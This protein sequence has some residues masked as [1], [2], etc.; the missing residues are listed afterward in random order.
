M[1]TIGAAIANLLT[2]IFYFLLYYL[3][4][5]RIYYIKYEVSKLITIALIG[6][7]LVLLSMATIE[8]SIMV[9]MSLK[10]VLFCSYPFLLYMMRFYDDI[11]LV[12]LQ[13]AWNKWKHPLQWKELIRSL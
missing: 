4:A 5:R 6:T 12:R 11:E 1:Q 13:Q 2:Q 9:R 3:T 7:M 10:I 8:L